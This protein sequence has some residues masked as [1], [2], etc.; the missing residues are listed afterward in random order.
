MNQSTVSR[1]V[2]VLSKPVQEALVSPVKITEAIG[3]AKTNED[4]TNMLAEEDGVIPLILD[5]TA[6]RTVRPIDPRKQ[7]SQYSG[8]KKSHGY[9]ILILTDI[10]GATIWTSDAFDGSTHDFSILKQSMAKL[11]GLGLLF[12]AMIKKNSG[13]KVKLYTD[14][15]FVGIEKILPGIISIQPLKRSKHEKL[16][17]GMSSRLPES[18]AQIT[19]T[20]AISYA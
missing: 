13:L 7:K 6:V 15:G 1:Y 5:G 12:E 19:L 10:H 11:N 2:S 4:I 20:V 16:T 9:T 8:K 3:A 14:L 18:C 17:E